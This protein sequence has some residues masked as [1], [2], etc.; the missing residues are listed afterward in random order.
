MKNRAQQKISSRKALR[1]KLVRRQA[2]GERIVFTSGCFDVLHIGH[3]RSVEEA[4]SLGDVLV[5]GVNRD[6][7]VRELKGRSRPVVPERQ[8][9]E[10]LAGFACVD[11]VV[12]F[13]EDTPAPLILSSVRSSRISCARAGSTAGLTSRRRRRSSPW[14]DASSCCGRCGGCVARVCS[15]VYHNPA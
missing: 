7:R 2:R 1:S 13:G 9:A 15:S 10:L 5:V 8:R 4:R 14:A 3:L 6:R 11:H 12:L